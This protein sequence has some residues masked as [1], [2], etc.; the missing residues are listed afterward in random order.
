[1][2]ALAPSFKYM[3]IVVIYTLYNVCAYVWVDEGVCV[4]VY[5]GVVYK[6]YHL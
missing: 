5:V 6:S 4:C 3:I 1:M 2:S